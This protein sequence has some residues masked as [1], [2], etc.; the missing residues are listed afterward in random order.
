M[1][2]K[3]Y[4]INFDKDNYKHHFGG[5]DWVTPVC[6]NC[7]EPY[8]QILSLDLNDPKLNT[9]AGQCSKCLPLISCL[10]CSSCW[11]EQ[12][13]KINFKEKTVEFISNNDTQHWIIDDELKI[14]VPLLE[15]PIT[16]NEKKTDGEVSEDDFWEEMGKDHFVSIL[17]DYYFNYEG[18]T[19]CDICGKDMKYIA[20]VC[21]DYG[22]IIKDFDFDLGETVLYFFFCNECSTMKV[23]GQST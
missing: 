3:S 15:Y 16:L 12:F 19:Q 23:I 8:H 10:N 7:G 1:N 20:T 13:F 21:S 9:I 22:N 17:G 4:T 18:N 11:E 6:S 14:N 5:N 2:N